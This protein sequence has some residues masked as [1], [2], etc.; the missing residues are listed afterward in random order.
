MYRNPFVQIKSEYILAFVEIL[1]ENVNDSDYETRVWYINKTK[2]L[3]LIRFLIFCLAFNGWTVRKSKYF[4][5]ILNTAWYKIPEAWCLT[6]VWSVWLVAW[7]IQSVIMSTQMHCLHYPVLHVYT[8]IGKLFK[9]NSAKQFIAA[10]KIKSPKMGDLLPLEMFRWEIARQKI[11]FSSVKPKIAA[12][13][14]LYKV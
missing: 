14:T 10:N 3:S 13:V 2:L 4:I 7:D 11:E 5:S 9:K 6:L 8:T 1:K 12:C